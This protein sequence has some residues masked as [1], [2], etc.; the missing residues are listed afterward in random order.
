MYKVLPPDAQRIHLWEQQ[1]PAVDD[2][3]NSESEWSGKFFA[4][5]LASFCR[6][7]QNITL[8]QGLTGLFLL[9]FP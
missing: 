6:K 4:K 1:L 3:Q 5:W 9:F 7:T 8:N 2:A